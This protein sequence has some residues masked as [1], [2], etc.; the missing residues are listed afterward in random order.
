VGH[1]HPEERALQAAPTTSRVCRFV[2]GSCNTDAA[3]KGRDNVGEH[4]QDKTPKR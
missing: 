4:E 2:Q 3:L 1:L